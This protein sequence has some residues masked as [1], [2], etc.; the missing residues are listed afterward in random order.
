MSLPCTAMRGRVQSR[1]D[2]HQWFVDTLGTE[3]LPGEGSF[4]VRISG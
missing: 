4:H 1:C 2:D 3:C